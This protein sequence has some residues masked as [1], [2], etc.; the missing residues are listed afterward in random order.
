MSNRGMNTQPNTTD[1]WRLGT[2]AKMVGASPAV[3][4]SA[5]ESGRIP[6]TVVTLGPRSHFV[7]V[8]EFQAWRQRSASAPALADEDL[9]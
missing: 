8:S 6:V 4:R 9:F 5:C 1:L 2:V 7:K 3:F